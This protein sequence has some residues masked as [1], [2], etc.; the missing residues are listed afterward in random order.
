MPRRC[1]PRGCLPGGR[2]V[3]P[4]GLPIFEMADDPIVNRMTERQVDSNKYVCIWTFKDT[5]VR[6]K[7][8]SLCN[9]LVRDKDLDI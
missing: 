1:L 7:P 2:G 4:G 3:C 6:K 5:Y 8:H 9:Q